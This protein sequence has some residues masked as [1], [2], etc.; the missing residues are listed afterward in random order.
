MV[1]EGFGGGSV[2]KT[3]GGLAF[4]G[5]AERPVGIFCRNFRRQS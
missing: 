2:F 5:S 3:F 4:V 1:A